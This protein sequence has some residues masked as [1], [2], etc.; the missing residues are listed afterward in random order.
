MVGENMKTLEVGKVLVGVEVGWRKQELLGDGGE[1]SCLKY[2]DGGGV[3]KQ[4]VPEGQFCEEQHERQFCL[5]LS[6]F[7]LGKRNT[8]I[9]STSFFKG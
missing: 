6:N 9:R 3:E 2:G 4:K 7:C 1:S 8:R 5:Y